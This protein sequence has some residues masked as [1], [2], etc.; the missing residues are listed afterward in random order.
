MPPTAVN[1]IDAIEN[2]ISYVNAVRLWCWHATPQC[3]RRLGYAN[4]LDDSGMVANSIWAQIVP[5]KEERDAIRYL[6][7]LMGG[8]AAAP[9]SLR[10]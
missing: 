4:F 6:V 5:Y 9:Q 1:N 2:D 8:D 3:A 10:R 7:Y